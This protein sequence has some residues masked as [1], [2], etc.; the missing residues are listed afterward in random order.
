MPAD[1]GQKRIN[2]LIEGVLQVCEIAPR[3]LRAIG[4]P[5]ERFLREALEG[6]EV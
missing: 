3:K 1:A 4:C 5:L 6:L 2:L